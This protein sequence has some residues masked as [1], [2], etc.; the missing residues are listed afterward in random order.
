MYKGIMK[1]LLLFC[2]LFLFIA[3]ASLGCWGPCETISAC[4]GVGGGMGTCASTD[5][6][7]DCSTGNCSAWCE[8]GPNDEYCVGTSEES[9]YPRMEHCSPIMDRWCRLNAGVDGNCG[10]R[11]PYETGSWCW[12]Q[13]CS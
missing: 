11:D 3:N 5:P 13:L 8:A 9:C 1:K 4:G 10:C 6:E 12:Q 2:A 7:E